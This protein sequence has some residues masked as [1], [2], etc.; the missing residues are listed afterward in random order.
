[1]SGT[2]VKGTFTVSNCIGETYEVT[3]SY[4]DLGRL[5]QA[6]LN[7]GLMVRDGSNAKNEHVIFHP[8][9]FGIAPYRSACIAHNHPG[10]YKDSER[11]ALAV[12]DFDVAVAPFRE[13]F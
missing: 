3:P 5:I 1:M 8:P 10:A 6:A 13:E 11:I 9:E 12:E 4:E 2:M 7:L